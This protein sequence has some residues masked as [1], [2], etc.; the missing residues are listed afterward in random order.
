MPPFII[1]LEA[2]RDLPRWGGL[3]RQD[4]TSVL[5]L[6]PPTDKSGAQIQYMKIRSQGWWFSMSKTKVSLSKSST[7]LSIQFSGKSFN[8]EKEH[9]NSCNR[10]ITTPPELRHLVAV[11]STSPHPVLRFLTLQH[12]IKHGVKELYQ[13]SYSTE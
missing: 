7:R 10:I 13:H 8:R 11:F 1:T 5:Q 12:V 3:N 4:W 6:G 9:W 2:L